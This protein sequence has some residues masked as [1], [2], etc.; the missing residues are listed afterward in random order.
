VIH[1]GLRLFDLAEPGTPGLAV[2]AGVVALVA[3]SGALAVLS[4][5]WVER[6]FLARKPVP[7]GMPAPARLGTGGEWVS[8]VST[9]LVRAR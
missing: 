2:A 5:R 7:Q 4:Y 1:H 9:Q 6:P 8:P 3:V